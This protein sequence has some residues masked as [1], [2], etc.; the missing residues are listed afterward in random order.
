MIIGPYRDKMVK[1]PGEEKRDSGSPSKDTVAPLRIPGGEPSL[2]E[3]TEH[4][5]ERDR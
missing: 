3:E 1:R 4:V 5:R 2:K